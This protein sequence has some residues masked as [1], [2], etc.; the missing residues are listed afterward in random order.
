MCGNGT[1]AGDQGER[2]SRAAATSARR[3]P[4]GSAHDLERRAA[5]VAVHRQPVGVGRE[6]EAVQVDRPPARRGSR[7]RSRRLPQGCTKGTAV[8]RP[9][10]NCASVRGHA[11]N[12]SPR[13]RNDAR[14]IP[15]P[16]GTWHPFAR[17]ERDR[18][19]ALPRTDAAGA[20]VESWAS[21]LLVRLVAGAWPRPRAAASAARI[22][23]GSWPT[24]S[25]RA[26][27][28][29]T[30]QRPSLRI[31]RTSA[32]W[33]HTAT[34][35]PFDRVDLAGDLTRVIGAQERDHRRDVFGLAHLEAERHVARHARLRAPARC[36][37]R[38]RRT[39][40]CPR[41]ALRTSET[42]PPLAAE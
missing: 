29:S 22:G 2:R 15:Q 34:R 7:Q 19:P 32:G 25:K 23:I 41:A 11:T 36:S 26:A 1:R 21:G 5:E 42:M 8:I 27:S 4:V 24:S 39:C 13:W 18:R 14:H 6:V 9:S 17:D 38:S 28:S 16:A 30:V 33:F 3:V 12:S 20:G 35:P 40:S 37:W 31:S 10:R